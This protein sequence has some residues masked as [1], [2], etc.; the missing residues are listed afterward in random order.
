MP[1]GPLLPDAAH[2]GDTQAIAKITI[3]DTFLPNLKCIILPVYCYEG[4]GRESLWLN[5]SCLYSIL[6]K[7]WKRASKK[8]QKNGK[9]H[10]LKIFFVKISYMR[11]EAKSW[12]EIKCNELKRGI[13]KLGKVNKVAIDRL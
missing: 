5:S 10:T 11:F 13:Y 7:Y 2:M 4:A 8:E 12:L 1:R 9:T 6:R 3:Q